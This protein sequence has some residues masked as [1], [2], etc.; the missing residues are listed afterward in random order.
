ML[1]QHGMTDE[2]ATTFVE[3]LRIAFGAGPAQAAAQ[4]AASPFVVKIEPGA[5]AASAPATGLGM[6]TLFT[7]GGSF[8]SQGLSAFGGATQGPSQEE[9]AEALKL[10]AEQQET[11]RLDWE[12]SRADA[13]TSLKQ[14]LEVQRLKHGAAAA[15]LAAAQE[16]A[17]KAGEAGG[18]KEEAERAAAIEKDVQAEQN[19]IEAMEVQRS[20][21]ESEAFG[22]APASKPARGSPF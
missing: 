12:Q 18:G 16:A 5:P 21:L 13:L 10:E 8:P 9:L 19:L 20:S 15:L 22:K 1:Q 14:R 7:A 17:K 6:M 3:A 2:V 11:Q 4:L